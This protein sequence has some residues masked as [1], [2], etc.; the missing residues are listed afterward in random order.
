MQD[1]NNHPTFSEDVYAK[2]LQNLMQGFGFWL[3][4]WSYLSLI[5]LT[6][7]V[8][9]IGLCILQCFEIFACYASILRSLSKTKSSTLRTFRIL[10]YAGL[11]TKTPCHI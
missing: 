11:V 5:L 7:E 1:S 2:T 4:D 9:G 8:G 6:W 10:C 3:P